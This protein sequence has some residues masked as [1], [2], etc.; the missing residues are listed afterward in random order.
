MLSLT[1]W[2]VIGIVV[3]ATS[4]APAATPTPVL[5]TAIPP[6]A[7]QTPVLPTA[8]LPTATPSPL[9]PTLTPVPATAT[10]TPVPPTT[11]PALPPHSFVVVKSALSGNFL[12]VNIRDTD[13][14]GEK[15]DTLGVGI[16]CLGGGI[17]VVDEKGSRLECVH[18]TEPKSPNQISMIFSGASSQHKYHLIRGGDPPIDLHPET[19]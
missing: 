2:F 9:P 8:I 1:K 17:H 11:T 4:C 7:T 16:E 15:L 19:P 10:P 6:T 3:L 5:P 18:V 13:S 12:G 14:D